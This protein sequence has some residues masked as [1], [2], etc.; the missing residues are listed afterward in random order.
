MRTLGYAIYQKIDKQS[1]LK[2]VV[3]PEPAL[4]YLRTNKHG[5]RYLRLIHHVC[6][7]LDVILNW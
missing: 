2:R 3:V 1:S 4:Y 5:R 6:P 7:D